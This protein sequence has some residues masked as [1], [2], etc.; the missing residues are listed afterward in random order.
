M[1]VLDRKLFA[2]VRMHAG[3]SPPHAP[4]GHKHDLGDPNLSDE[5]Y[6]SKLAQEILFGINEQEDSNTFSGIMEGFG[7]ATDEKGVIDP[8]ILAETIYPTRSDEDLRAEAEKLYSTDLS[9]ERAEVERQ[10]QEDV[11]SSLIGFGAR[12][13]TGRG[14]A[15]DVLGQA[16]EETLP[17]FMAARRATRKDVMTL[18]GQE[19]EAKKAISA[20]VMTKQQED[21]AKKAE[22]MIQATF[23]NLDF[24]QETEKIEMAHDWD[25][26]TKRVPVTNT[27]TGNNEEITL[28]KWVDDQKL[29]EIQRKYMQA[30]DYNAPFVA[31][32]T[33][34]NANRMFTDYQAF[35]K[36]NKQNPARFEDKKEDVKGVEV[37][38]MKVGNFTHPST[39]EYGRWM[40]Q[41]LDNGTYM[42][43]QL[44]ENGDVLLQVNGQPIMI[45]IGQGASDLVVGQD[46]ELKAEDLL[47][48][49]VQMEQL[50]TILLYDRNIR[51]IDKI[52]T[53]IADKRTRA[54]IMGSIDEM[55]Q[56]G[57]GMIT[58]ILDADQK[59]GI[60]LAVKEE[61]K[62]INRIAETPDDAAAI[63]ALFDPNN[64]S[65][66]EFW[67]EFDQALAENRTRANAIAYA[68][69]R[70]RKTSGR[71]NLDD[72]KNAR[73]SLHIT[74]FKDARTAIVEL[75]TIR[76]ELS[77]AND[78]LKLIYTYYGGEFPE[79]Y[80]GTATRKKEDLPIPI[81]K[82]LKDGTEVIDTFIF[83]WEIKKP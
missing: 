11:A 13:M 40:I 78:D 54:G 18:K 65:Y 49:K 34:F 10:K 7:E 8:R 67:G 63:K 60:F 6:T 28:R 38:S 22:L 41:E 14:N 51:S 9:A 17:E 53:N 26:D 37:K 20:Y 16:A 5:Q 50:S 35:A 36:A 79:G 71:L 64:K 45:P 15:L 55:I 25:L 2:P 31:W 47:P 19:K 52:I 82:T 12:L 56:I 73:Q 21:A 58:D 4:A 75:D 62:S 57:E 69:A 33:Y 61:L 30:T 44:D 59:N 39:G 66:D 32:D 77:E 27:V 68:V 48:P 72:I 29:P 1:S 70:A 76:K 3:G 80:T 24:S 81:Y 74:G 43:P 83:P 46:V 23:K 42:M